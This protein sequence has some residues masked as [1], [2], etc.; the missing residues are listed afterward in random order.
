MLAHRGPVDTSSERV[1]TR[2]RAGQVWLSPEDGLTLLGR[3]SR[4]LSQLKV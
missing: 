3:G 1:L 2:A 4:F